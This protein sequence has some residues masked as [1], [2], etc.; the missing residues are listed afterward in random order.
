MTH[1]EMK[2]KLKKELQISKFGESSFGDLTF[3]LSKT[4][5][6][7]DSRLPRFVAVYDERTDRII[8]TAWEFDAVANYDI[9]EKLEDKLI[10]IINAKDIKDVRAM[11]KE[12]RAKATK[13]PKKKLKLEDTLNETTDV[14]KT[15]KM[16]TDT[17]RKKIPN[18]SRI[19]SGYNDSVVIDY[20]GNIYSI[21]KTMNQ[22]KFYVTHLKGNS[23]GEY[24]VRKLEDL[25]NTPTRKDAIEIT[26]KIRKTAKKLPKKKMKLEN[27]LIENTVDNLLSSIS[28]NIKNVL[29]KYHV[30]VADRKRI[31]V[32]Y[33]TGLFTRAVK[34]S[35]I[36]YEIDGKL[37]DIRYC[38]TA[39]R[40]TKKQEDL[41]TVEREKI[42]KAWQ[43]VDM[44]IEDSVDSKGFNRKEA[45][46]IIKKYNELNY[47][48]F[49]RAWPMDVEGVKDKTKE[50]RDTST[51]LPKK[52]MKLE[53][54]VNG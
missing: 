25:L 19:E 52:T 24:I 34:L 5:P 12:I 43:D 13:L 44:Y 40:V 11:T 54:Y 48:Y 21:N 7:Y 35:S 26:K 46:G 1:N 41:I 8:M 4:D 33:S 53:D 42:N 36:F 50:I 37:M 45:L 28:D 23:G 18:V 9:V 22:D 27:V 32:D 39:K 17:I 31:G 3:T 47:K 6:N 49:T 10:E 16:I 29:D 38:K 15:Q 14:E 20:K 30:F 2:K 51:K